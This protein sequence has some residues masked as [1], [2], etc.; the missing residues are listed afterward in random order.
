MRVSK[1]WIAMLVV[2]LVALSATASAAKE[3]EEDC[4][5]KVRLRGPLWDSTSA[6]LEPSLAPILDEI[7]RVIRT[8]CGGKTIL[9]EA[10]AFEMP[11]AA[12]NQ[13]LSELRVML[14]THELEKRGVKGTQLMPVAL[15]D[16]RPIAPK[17]DRDAA[18]ENRRITFR[19]LD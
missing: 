4:V 1:G 5:G 19:V 15:G 14:V 9:V 3:P 13:K 8:D 6:A 2:A 7:A 10:H 12:L 17:D 16:T 18:V 11:S